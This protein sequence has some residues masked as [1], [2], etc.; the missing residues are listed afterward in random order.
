MAGLDFSQ[1]GANDGR[2]ADWFFSQAEIVV[3]NGTVRWTDESHGDE[4]VALQN[5]TFVARNRGQRHRL[6]LDA[7][8]PADFGRPFT[9][10]AEFRQPLWTRRAGQWQ[11]WEGQLYADFPA[12]D[13]ARLHRQVPLGVEVTRGV[14]GWRRWA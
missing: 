10:Q 13:V 12:V 6:R 3:S 1:G 14:G 11:S 2:G 9:V 7:T 4:T 5:L 8:P